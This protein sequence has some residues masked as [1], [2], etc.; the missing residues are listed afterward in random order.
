MVSLVF[1]IAHHY[2]S[3]LLCLGWLLIGCNVE[4]WWPAGKS[5]S[6]RR[7]GR[8]AESEVRH[9][10]VLC[11]DKIVPHFALYAGDD[12]FFTKMSAIPPSPHFFCVVE[13]STITI[14]P[15][16]NPMV[17]LSNLEHLNLICDRRTYRFHFS[18][19]FARNLNSFRK[20]LLL[21]QFIE[22]C[23]SDIKFIFELS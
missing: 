6:R 14:E 3:W 7:S 15:R 23:F 21:L 4:G 16:I 1:K 17:I 9:V 2:V 12:S 20:F 8:S 13:L 5:R 19:K 22:L 18:L 11:L 10:S